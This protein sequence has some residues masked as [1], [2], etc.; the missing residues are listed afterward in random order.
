MEVATVDWLSPSI[1]EPSGF[2][3]DVFTP[4]KIYIDPETGEFT[5]DRPAG[6][7]EGPKYVWDAVLLSITR[8]PYRIQLE[9]FIDEGEGSLLFLF[10][11][12]ELRKTVRART[13]K[14]SVGAAASE[15]KLLAA[16]VRLVEGVDGSRTR[17]A[18][19]NILDLRSGEEKTLVHRELLFEDEVTILVASDQDSS[20]QAELK[21]V[22]DSFTTIHGTYTLQ[23]INL[24]ESAIT[25]EKAATP[26]FEPQTRTLSIATP[27]LD[28]A[29]QNEIELTD[30]SIAPETAF[31]LFFQ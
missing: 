11:D 3:Y 7:D 2:K 20:F 5:Q 18:T 23:E 28:K 30:P 6:P 29:E 16:D 8:E 13:A 22:G 19:A 4:F 27:V 14:Q 25:V 31:D 24:E 1:Q 10:H 12:V 17:V 21:E 26:D 15:F 9:G